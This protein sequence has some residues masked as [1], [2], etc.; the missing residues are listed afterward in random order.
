MTLDRIAP[1]LFV[2][3]WST[4]WIVAKYASPHADP[5]TFLSIRFTA[6]NAVLFAFI[7]T[8]RAVPCLAL[9]PVRLGA[10]LLLS[11]RAPPWD[12]SGGRV[13]GDLARRAVIRIRSDCRASAVADGHSQHRSSLASG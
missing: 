7:T 5:L 1:A 10:M 6:G 2:L 4:G 3:L 11:G 8:S 13:V 9:E 12:L